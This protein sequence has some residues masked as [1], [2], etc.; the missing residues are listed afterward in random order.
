MLSLSPFK[1]KE[2]FLLQANYNSSNNSNTNE[3]ASPHPLRY[4]DVRELHVSQSGDEEV[5]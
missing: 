5:I 3:L 1:I 4:Y 2:T